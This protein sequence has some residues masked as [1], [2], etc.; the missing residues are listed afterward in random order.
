[1]LQ[2]G[3]IVKAWI[4]EQRQG[5]ILTPSDVHGCDGIENSVNKLCDLMQKTEDVT[6]VVL[7]ASKL[8]YLVTAK[9]NAT[10][11]TDS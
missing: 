4:K 11:D 6:P 7:I 1:M 2:T 5:G 3:K 9:N 8:G 10:N